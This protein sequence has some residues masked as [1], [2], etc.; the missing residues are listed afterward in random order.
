MSPTYDGLELKILVSPFAALAFAQFWL[1][2]Q[3]QVN[4]QSY[5]I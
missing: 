2:I 1:D 5:G 3:M 4:T